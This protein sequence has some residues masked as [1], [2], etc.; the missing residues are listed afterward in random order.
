M[1]FSWVLQSTSTRLKTLRHR[2]SAAD[3]LPR[4]SSSPRHALSND[5][6]RKRTESEGLRSASLDAVEVNGCSEITMARNDGYICYRPEKN[7]QARTKTLMPLMLEMSQTCTNENSSSPTV[8]SSVSKNGSSTETSKSSHPWSANL[9]D[10]SSSASQTT[11]DYT[12]VSL[13]TASKE[14]VPLSRETPNTSA[15]VSLAKASPSDIDI[16]RDHAHSSPVVELS[17]QRLAT[18]D[19]PSATMSSSQDRNVTCSK[20]SNFSS[21]V[22]STADVDLYSI[23]AAA[24]GSGSVPSMPA[25][26]FVLASSSKP[27]NNPPS[28][29]PAVFPPT[30]NDQD[31]IPSLHCKTV[32]NDCFVELALSL[33]IELEQEWDQRISSPLSDTIRRYVDAEVTVECVMARSTSTGMVKPTILLMCSTPKHK[34]QIEKILRR[35]NYISAH[36]R[37]KVAVL[38]NQRCTSGNFSPEANTVLPGQKIL[39]EMA[40]DEKGAKSVV[41]GSLAKFIRDNDADLTAFSTI[42]GAIL[43]AGT[44]YGLTTA[45]GIH[46]VSNPRL[47]ATRFSGMNAKF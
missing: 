27:E 6:S 25:N 16:L 11:T 38:E 22:S 32:A 45:H 36:F 18:D 44:L 5:K 28:A 34:R 41:F 46:N 40:V 3:I 42:G 26:G 47:K 24:S 2:K 29:H 17:D 20:A 33:P 37:R 39:V 15:D 7:A 1:V 14:F 9:A 4:Q 30:S 21:P 43:I 13:Q 23:E 35:C 8:E 12:T 19:L 31:Q 10:D